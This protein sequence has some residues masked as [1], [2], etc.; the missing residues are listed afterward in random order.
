MDFFICEMS[1]VTLVIFF[2][3]DRAKSILAQIAAILMT[4]LPLALPLEKEGQLLGRKG[5]KGRRRGW[6]D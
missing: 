6:D 4:M 5:G 1:V 2:L 3:R